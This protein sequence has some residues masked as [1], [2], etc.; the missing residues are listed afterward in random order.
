MM[1]TISAL[2]LLAC[3]IVAES[4]SRDKKTTPEPTTPK[5]KTYDNYTALK[6]G[7]YW[8]YRSYQYTPAGEFEATEDYDSCYIEKD[9]SIG[10]SPYYKYCSG[11]VGSAGVSVRYLRDSLSYMVDHE[12]IIMFSSEDMGR[13]FRTYEWGPNAATPLTFTVTEQMIARDV[14][15]EVPAGK[16]ETYVFSRTYHYPPKVADADISIGTW[17]AK[18]VG[19]VKQTMAVYF[20][21]PQ[22]RFENRLV[23]YKVE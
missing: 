4:C 11:R 10:G 16:F 13:V 15:L 20:S 18:G 23:R 22:L 6:P 12:G 8:I 14:T 9:T 17:Y 21:D 2:L 5:E 7:N 1:K 3:F 19:V